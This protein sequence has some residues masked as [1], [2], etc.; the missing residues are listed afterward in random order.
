MSWLTIGA[1]QLQYM[2]VDKEIISIVKA[3]L[4]LLISSQY[5]LRKWKEKALLKEGTEND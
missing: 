2:G 4:V 5:F 1:T 3:V